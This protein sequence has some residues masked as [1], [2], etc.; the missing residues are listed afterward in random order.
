MLIN[1]GLLLD[2]FANECD[3][4]STVGYIVGIL[5]CIGSICSYIPQFY[6]IFKSKA[7][8]GLSEPSIV[9][10]NVGN[11]CL[12]LN[13]IIFNW[14]KWSCFSKCSFGVCN[15]YMLPFYQILMGWVMV[16]I[17]Y[18]IFM[19]YKIRNT[20]DKIIGAM[21]YLLLYIVFIGVVVV[22]AISEKFW[23]SGESRLLFFDGFGQAMGYCAALCNGVV[24]I[25]QIYVLLKSGECGNVSPVMFA[26]Q[27]PGNVVIIIFQAVLYKQPISTWISYVV[28]CIEQTIVLII[29]IMYKIRDRRM[30]QEF[31]TL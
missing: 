14:Y 3:L 6:V 27:A 11:F 12:T 13:S 15:A 22:I 28:C 29:I 24:W 4:I 25:H 23:N 17:F 19:K 2:S 9:I 5:L 21:F 26:L 16:F 20:E 18:L 10:L 8:D 1:M 31:L 7:I 30:N